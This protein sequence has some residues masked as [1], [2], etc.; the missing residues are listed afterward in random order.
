[1]HPETKRVKDPIDF[2]KFLPRDQMIAILSANVIQIVDS[3]DLQLRQE[4]KTRKV[5]TFCINTAVYRTKDGSGDQICVASTSNTLY[6]Y[7]TDMSSGGMLFK[8]DPKLDKG[9]Q[10]GFAP[11]QLFWDGERIYMAS[12]RAYVVMNKQDGA[13]LYKYEINIKGKRTRF[14]DLGFRHSDDGCV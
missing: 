12:K 11:Q 10:I 5:T 13:I 2:I 7:D 9:Y 1:M 14:D 3:A 8:E 4:L 6:F